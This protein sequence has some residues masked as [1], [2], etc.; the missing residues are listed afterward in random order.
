MNRLLFSFLGLLFLCAGAWSAEP[1][2]VAK[3]G[4]DG[5]C[6]LVEGVK[7]VT[8]NKTGHGTISTQGLKALIQSKVPLIILDAREA[9]YDNGQR[10]PGAKSMTEQATPEEIRT[11]IPSK[12]ALVITYCSNP[13][14]PASPAL[15]D[16]LT[17]LGYTNVLEYPEGLA[18]WLD[19]GYETFNVKH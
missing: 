19:A 3:C 4:A 8:E 6:T 5:K 1:R 2:L 10:I 16:R 13:E 14:C 15:A 12:D 9:S 7:V 18:G 17:D 11:I